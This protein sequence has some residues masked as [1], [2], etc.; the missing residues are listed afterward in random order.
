M[1]GVVNDSVLALSISIGH[2][3]GLFDTMAEL[4]AVDERRDRRRGGPARA[5]RARGAGRHD[6]RRHRRPTTAA[7]RTY[8]L[9]PEHAAS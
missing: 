4:A 5:I 6:D 2:Q 1:V 9:P 8:G 3:T 7:T